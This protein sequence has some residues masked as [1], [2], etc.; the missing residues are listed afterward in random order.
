MASTCFWNGTTNKKRLK[1]KFNRYQK[2]RENKAK[3]AQEIFSF[4]H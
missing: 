4:S 2:V 1:P 3:T